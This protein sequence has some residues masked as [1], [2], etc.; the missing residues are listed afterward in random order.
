MA[1]NLDDFSGRVKAYA[2][3]EVQKYGANVLELAEIAP[4]IICLRDDYSKGEAD[5]F[6]DTQLW[7]LSPNKVHTFPDAALPP[8]KETR[9][10]GVLYGSNV[11]WGSGSFGTIRELDEAIILA[12][13]SLVSIVENASWHETPIIL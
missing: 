1:Q 13:G 9:G 6:F 12:K 8:T 7:A 3:Q 5:V 11:T 4:G 10:V 2:T